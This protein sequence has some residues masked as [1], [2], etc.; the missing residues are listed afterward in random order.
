MSLGPRDRLG[1]L[2]RGLTLG[3]APPAAAAL[4]GSGL[5]NRRLAL[6]AEGLEPR[7]PSL[8]FEVA[9]HWLQQS[10]DA[11]VSVRSYSSTPKRADAKAR[12]RTMST[13]FSTGCKQGRAWNQFIEG[14]RGCKARIT[15]AFGG[16]CRKMPAAS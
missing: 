15:V 2:S 14:M 16:Q 4:K 10:T 1:L 11:D 3:A 13:M 8:R 12:F 5:A 7:S 9:C 6:A